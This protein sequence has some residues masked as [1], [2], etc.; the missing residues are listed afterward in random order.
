MRV[1]EPVKFARE[2]DRFPGEQAIKIGVAKQFDFSKPFEEEAYQ[3]V[4][5][6]L[7]EWLIRQVVP[8]GKVQS[9]RSLY[10][11]VMGIENNEY[12]VPLDFS[13]SMGYPWLATHHGA[14]KKATLARL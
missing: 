1:R 7:S 5:R 14:K 11:G 4:R 6:H 10:E 12:A 2:G 3:D 13:T 8:I 9:V